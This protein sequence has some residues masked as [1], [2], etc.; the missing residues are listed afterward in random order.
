[1][2]CKDCKNKVIESYRVF[3]WCYDNSD[4]YF[5]TLKEAKK[6]Y[7]ESIKEEPLLDWRLYHHSWCDHCEWDN[8]DCL[9]S[10][11][12]ETECEK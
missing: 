1:M 7:D 3:N 8:E 12:F 10:Q 4:I 11:L 2:K 9:E 6:A 5:N